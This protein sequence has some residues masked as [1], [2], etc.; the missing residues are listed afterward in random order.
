VCKAR[1]GALQRRSEALEAELETVRRGEERWSDLDGMYRLLGH[2]ISRCLN[3][4]TSLS[5]ATKQIV[6]GQEPNVSLLLG[7]RDLSGNKG[8]VE[9][10]NFTL[11]EQYT[12]FLSVEAFQ[13]DI[14]SSRHDGRVTLLRE[15]LSE[16][17]SIRSELAKIREA[18]S[19][20]YAENLGDNFTSCIT[21]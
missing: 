3:E 5:Q 7:L 17:K 10:A 8:E 6:G 19:E 21:Q 12:S 16:A 15:Q 1:I 20:K 4:L 9:M 18:V 11:L 14:S 2:E 13:S